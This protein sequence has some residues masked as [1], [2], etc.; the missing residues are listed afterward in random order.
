MFLSPI[1]APVGTLSRSTVL[2]MSNRISDGHASCHGWRSTFRSWMADHGIEF[3]VA[4]AALAHSSAAVVAAYQRS[5][6]VERRRPIMAAWAQFLS[7][8]EQIA[9]IIPLAARR[10]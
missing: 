7:G 2:D 4:E 6:L 9:E 10:A 8:E 1:V 3:E 5:S